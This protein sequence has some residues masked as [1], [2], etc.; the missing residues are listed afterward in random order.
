MARPHPALIDLAAGRPMAMK[1]DSMSLVASA[2]EHRMG[3]LL[4]SR[5]SSGELELDPE[6]A[7]ILLEED[8]VLRGRQ[9][10]MW[11]VLDDVARKLEAIDIEIAV[12]KGIIAQTRWYDRE[13]ERPCVDLDVLLPPGAEA[14]A[15]DVLRALQPTHRLTAHADRL[16]SS[17]ALQSLELRVKEVPIDLHFD[18]LKLGIPSRLRETIWSRM[19]PFE[20]SS[21]RSVRVPDPEIALMQFLVHLNKDRFRYLLGLAD[22]A[23]ILS[24]EEVDWRSLADLARG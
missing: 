16:A 7:R 10:R 1:S 17:G 9:R 20:T 19:I 11:G 24:R 3:G 8:L 22:V 15:G 2:R 18:M 6:A 13:G 21:G 23:R 5:A 4:W 14:R 12:F